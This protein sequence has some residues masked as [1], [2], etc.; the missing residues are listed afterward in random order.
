MSEQFNFISVVVPVYGCRTCLWQLV[1]ELV[2]VFVKIGSGYEIILVNDA[3]PD[4]SWKVVEEICKENRH[5]IGLN[6]SRNFG[7]HAAI[8]AGLSKVRGDWVVVMDCDLQDRPSEIE[9][10]CQKAQ[11]GYDVVLASRNNRQDNFLKKWFSSKFYK[12]L[13]YL[14]DTEQDASIANFGIYRRNVIEAI[15]SMGDNARY[16]PSMVNWVGFRRA[17]V[18]VQHGVRF[19]G[20]TSYNFS[21]LFKL[22]LD[23]IFAF[24]DKP[25]RL[26]IKLGLVMALLA[27]LFAVYNVVLYHYDKIDEPGWATVVVSIWFLSGLIIFILGIVGLYIGKTYEK[28]KNRP[29]FIIEQIVNNEDDYK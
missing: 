9:R 15:L 16:L 22:A 7:Q 14:T 28:V 29:V 3:S 26:T 11:E 18:N 21:A 13:S 10:L 1:K 4:M 24:S 20:K 19:H 27:L 8:T 17:K 23:V 5:V 2:A 12:L 6:L 25:L